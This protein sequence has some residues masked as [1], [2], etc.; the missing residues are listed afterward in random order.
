MNLLRK[1]STVL[2]VI[3]ILFLIILILLKNNTIRDNE[4][5][6]QYLESEATTEQEE[7]EQIEDES[8]STDTFEEDIEW[9]VTTVYESNDRLQL[10]EEIQDSVNQNVLTALLGEDLPPEESTQEEASVERSVSNVDVFGK[11]QGD[12][13]YRA[14]VLLD[15]SYEYKDQEDE[16][17]ILAYLE[18]SNQEGVWI[19][20]EFRE[21]N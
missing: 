21:V 9:F 5:T 1:Y 6:I 2:W 17:E 7:T 4:E 15:N 11:Y 16:K 19:I 3:A 13:K 10:Y 18:I 20:T 8:E 14:V 12:D